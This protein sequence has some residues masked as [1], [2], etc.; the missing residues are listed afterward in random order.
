MTLDASLASPPAIEAGA[1]MIARTERIAIE[2]PPTEVFAYVVEGPLARMIPVTRRLPGVSGTSLLTAGPWGGVGQRRHVHLTDG[3]QTTEQVLEAVPGERFRYEVWDY[4][5]AA[6]RPI[7]YALGDFRFAAAGAGART[8]LAWTY[9]FRLR[10][11]VFPGNLGGLGR[12][13]MR[14]AFID[15]AYAQLMRASLAAIKAQVEG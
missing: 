2:R 7:A 5:T 11:D 1:P 14:L 9:A 13:L 6:A 10:P 8:D 3:S 4:S 12:R 15:T